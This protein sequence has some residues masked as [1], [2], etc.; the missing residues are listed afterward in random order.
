M[1]TFQTVVAAIHHEPVSD[2]LS[3]GKKKH[4]TRGYTK[5]YYCIIAYECTNL[6]VLVPFTAV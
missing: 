5:E 1:C 3:F 6:D 2:Q 4:L